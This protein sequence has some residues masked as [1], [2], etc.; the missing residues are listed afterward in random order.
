VEFCSC[1]EFLEISAGLSCPQ[2]SLLWHPQKLELAHK[3]VV[4]HFWHGREHYRRTHSGGVR[5]LSE[6]FIVKSC[7]FKDEDIMSSPQR[8]CHSCRW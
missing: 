5:I 1:V 2:F 6:A 4:N 3:Q 8:W 7:L